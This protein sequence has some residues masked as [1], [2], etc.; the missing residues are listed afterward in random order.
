MRGPEPRS[1]MRGWSALGAFV[2]AAVAVTATGVSSGWLQTVLGL[3]LVLVIPGY[4]LTAVFWP[5]RSL[6]L[7]ERAAVAVG[8]S[9]ALAA[10][11]GLL[12]NWLP[13]GVS[14]RRSA[15][16][17]GLVALGAITALLV[18][19]RGRAAGLDNGVVASGW[20]HPR[21]FLRPHQAVLL[22][23]ALG[24][25]VA[26]VGVAVHSAQGDAGPGFTQAWMLP[27]QVGSG[28]LTVGLQNDEH[29]AHTYHLQLRAGPRVV[30]EWDGVRLDPG[31]R[32]STTLTVPAASVGSV[33]DLS[34]YRDDAPSRVYRQVRVSLARS[35]P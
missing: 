32:F 5:P 23:A 1:S 19:E 17:L 20:S 11:S 7:A 3:P 12:L 15:V 31:Q 8:V 26:G 4:A 35:G 25:V 29:R 30:R 24:L 14:G 6:G 18:R 22:A 21:A 13:G 10:T 2:V 33:A 9:L 16:L 28:S 27:N 34:V